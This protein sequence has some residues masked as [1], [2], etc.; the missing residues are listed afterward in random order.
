[1]KILQT[2]DAV[3]LKRDSSQ[4]GTI[5]EVDNGIN[6]TIYRVDFGYE[7]LSLIIDRDIEEIEQ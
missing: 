2:G 1:M 7:F 6:G 5:V 4:V 3:R